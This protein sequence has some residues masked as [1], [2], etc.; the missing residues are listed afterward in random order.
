MKPLYRHIQLN[1]EPR[2]LAYNSSQKLPRQL[3]TLRMSWQRK[4]MPV[5]YIMVIFVYKNTTHDRNSDVYIYTYFA[6]TTENN[7]L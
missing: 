5:N 6:I 2:L 3:S 1:M 7:E 4:N